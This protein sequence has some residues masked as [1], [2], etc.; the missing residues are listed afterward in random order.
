MGE[1]LLRYPV[2]SPRAASTP[3]PPGCKLSQTDSPTSAAE[4]KTITAIP[5]SSAIG[6]LMYLVVSTR[7]D[8]S[9][10]VSCLSRFNHNPGMA[11]W[12]GVQHVLRYFC[13]AKHQWGGSMF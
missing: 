13:D 8:I 2:V 6:S 1:V 4:K 3:L 5:Y 9:T 10:A 12:E 11:H 7:T